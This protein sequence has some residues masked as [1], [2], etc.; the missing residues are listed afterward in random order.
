MS[1]IATMTPRQRFIT[2]LERKGKPD[3]VPH[4]ELV[5]FLTM[6]A[7]G[8]VHP[9]HRNLYQWDQMS[10]T[11]KDLYLRNTAEL[12]IKIAEKYE[13]DAIYLCR[14]RWGGDA[15]LLRVID[16][17]R[18][19]SGDKYC[20]MVDADGTMS[21]PS[22]EGMTEISCRMGDE[23]DKV[24]E[25]FSR[26]SDA[27]IE[28]MKKYVDH[29]G[30]DGV[31]MCC[32]YCFNT[33]PFLS[34]AWFDKFVTPFL[35][36]E[37]TAYKQ[38]GLYTIK[39]TDGNIMPILDSLLEGKPDA[40]HSLDPQGGIDMAEMVRVAGDRV[41]LCGNVSCS[42]LQTGTDAECVESA[43]YALEHGKQAEGYIFCTSNC[44]YSGMELSRYDLI[45]DVWKN[46][47][48]Y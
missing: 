19:I 40:I 44:V 12:Y 27:E 15:E 1:P 22:G 45:Q 25:E 17:I 42:A 10:A 20:I 5:F 47:R 30:V 28:R 38:M 29:G 9:W 2:A 24:L 36:R 34:P 23:P 8:E 14:L 33:G 13:H 46:M 37:L 48:N 41:T 43:R 16:I 11:E 26:R 35:V 4:F 18:E 21:V 7:F 32:D 31:I 39:H 3:H 6:E